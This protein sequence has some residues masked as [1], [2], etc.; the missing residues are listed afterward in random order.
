M[1]DG[2]INL[3]THT[4]FSDGTSTPEEYIK[5]ALDAGLSGLG[6]SDHAYVPADYD[7]GF[8]MK[9]GVQPEYFRELQRLK[10]KYSGQL[11]IF[12][13]LEGDFTHMPDRK[14]LDYLIGSVHY[15]YDKTGKKYYCVD[16]Y[17]DFA[18]ERMRDGMAGGDIK[19]LVDIYYDTVADMVLRYKPDILGHIDLIVKRNEISKF[20]SNTSAWYLDAAARA[21]AAVK[22]A[23][24]ILEMNTGAVNRGFTTYPYPEMGILKQVFAAGIPVTISSDAHRAEN[25]VS[26]F[27]LAK[28][29]LREAGY[30]C[31]LQMQG[32]K[33]VEVKL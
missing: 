24:C 7:I 9:S 30:R 11:E 16:D 28:T 3:H 4:T 12:I 27:S 14:G 26:N 18:V 17:E 6:F 33:F 25:L 8:S 1:T 20:L 23:G 13:G 19:K 10:E 5:A 15:L 32:G 21:V 31:T 29:L 2:I 22:K